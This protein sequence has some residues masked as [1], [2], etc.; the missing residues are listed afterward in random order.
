V[1]EENRGSSQNSRYLDQYSTRSHPEQ[2]AEAVPPELTCP[3]K[4]GKMFYTKINKTKN[5]L[6][7]P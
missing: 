7:G 4:I 1:T 2:R 6:H 5:K 3:G